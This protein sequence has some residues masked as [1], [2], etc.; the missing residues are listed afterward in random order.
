MPSSKEPDKPDKP[1]RPDKPE[2]PMVKPDKVK[3]PKID[4]HRLRV[5]KTPKLQT[6][7][8]IKGDK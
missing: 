4:R 1:D 5:K 2:R 3:K 7:H 6:D 8:T